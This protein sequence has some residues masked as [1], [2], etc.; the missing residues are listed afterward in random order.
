MIPW[1]ALAQAHYH[2]LRLPV[3]ILTGDADEIITAKRQSIRL[4]DE[5]P[6]SSLRVLPGLGHM[7]HYFAQDEIA[8]S[9]EAVLARSERR[10][11]EAMHPLS[12]HARSMRSH[13]SDAVVSSAA[14]Y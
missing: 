4:H 6:H 2:K 11:D 13:A 14:A 3:A 9:V 10:T 5:I 8:A 12:D 1:A 7:I